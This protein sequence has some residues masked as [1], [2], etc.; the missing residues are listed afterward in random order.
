VQ[1]EIQT[2]K[3]TEAWGMGLAAEALARIKSD[4][5]HKHVQAVN[6]RRLEWELKWRNRKKA[7]QLAETQ[8]SKCLE[9]IEVA[10]VF[11]FI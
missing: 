7:L 1:P 10:L 11:T 4:L 3:Y 2:C 9:L 6:A 5:A 8:F